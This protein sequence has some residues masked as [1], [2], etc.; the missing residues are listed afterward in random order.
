MLAS[1][2]ANKT[3]KKPANMLN[4]IEYCF[5]EQSF[6]ATESNHAFP[7]NNLFLF[8]NPRILKMRSTKQKP[9]IKKK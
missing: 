2:H 7:F 8:S 6:A 3:G 4:D 1:S 9:L 5:C